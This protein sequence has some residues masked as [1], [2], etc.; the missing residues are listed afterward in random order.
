M[1][2]TFLSLFLLLLNTILA[3][4]TITAAEYFIDTDPG[5]GNATPITISNETSLLSNFNVST[6]ALTEGTHQLHVR[7]KDNLD[8]WSMYARKTFLIRSVNQLNTKTI[9]GIEYFI[10]TDPGVENANGI[11]VANEN[12]L[13]DTFNISSNSISQGFHW[14]HFRVKNN[15]DTW[16]LYARKLI[17]IVEEFST[18]DIIAAEFFIDVDPGVGNA[19]SIDITQGPT[20]NETLSIE[21]PN[22]LGE[23]DHFL[24][25]RVLN[26]NGKWSLYARPEFES[27]LGSTDFTFEYMSIYPNPVS[28]KL[29]FSLGDTSIDKITLI[30]LTGKVISKF[31]EVSSYI[32]MV[33]LEAGTYLLQITTTEGSISK[34]II[35]K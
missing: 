12:S 18:N 32:S 11:S 28:D 9:N 15:N 25:I 29:Y 20:I 4:E 35:K 1:K 16:S 6:I 23:G 34:K 21:I 8:Q 22:D 24:H 2:T 31:S 3:Q 30:D 14:L 17:Y 5:V 19:T 33:D 10:D 7:V 13:N 26:S 27:T